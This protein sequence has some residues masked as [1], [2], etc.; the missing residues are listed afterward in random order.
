TKMKQRIQKAIPIFVI[1]I[2]LLFILRGL[3]LGI[4]YLSPA[5]IIETAASAIDCH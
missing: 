5:P 2:G 1:I 3:G 4:P